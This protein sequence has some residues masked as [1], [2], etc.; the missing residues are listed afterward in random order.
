[1]AELA[2]RESDRG[3][4]LLHMIKSHRQ[5]L[6]F[7]PALIS[8]A[9]RLAQSS[10]GPEAYRGSVDDLRNHLVKALESG[11]VRSGRAI[12]LLDALDE[13]ESGDDR[14][15]F[16]LP[17]LP[18]GVRAVLTCRPDVPLVQALRAHLRGNLTERNVPA[19]SPEDFR[20]MLERRLESTVVRSL[21]RSVDFDALFERMGGNPLFLAVFADDLAQ[22]WAEAAG[23][24]QPL[25]VNP[26]EV[27]ATLEAVFRHVC[28]RVRGRRN[29]QAFPLEGRQRA[30]L[31]L[32]A[33][34][35]L[36]RGWM[37]RC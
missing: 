32:T 15:R 35:W 34:A 7:V 26:D 10:F 33:G 4:C 28:D 20:L 22:R 21:E 24:G 19:L 11:R 18:D 8:Q 3:G 13:L 14:L 2:R 37:S 29:G 23:A 12:L 5:P 27:P 6:R 31:L 1:M 9:A 30:R 16:L 17:R 25:T 36:E